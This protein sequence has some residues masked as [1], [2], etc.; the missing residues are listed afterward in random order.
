VFARV[1]TPKLARESK[2]NGNENNSKG[3]SYYFLYDRIK[4]TFKFTSSYY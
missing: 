4:E 2:I 3:G 1:F